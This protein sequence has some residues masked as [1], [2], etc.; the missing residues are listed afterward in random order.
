MIVE[1]DWLCEQLDDPSV[2]ILDAS[3]TPVSGTKSSYEGQFIAGARIFDIDHFSDHLSPLPHMLATASD[4]QHRARFLGI[5]KES[6][7]I[8]YDNQGIYSSPRAWWMFKAMGHEKVAVLNGGL[9][10]WLEKGYPVEK[11]PRSTFPAGNFDASLNDSLVRS[12]EQVAE[13]MRSRSF[14][15]IDARSAR[16]FDGTHPEPR[17]HLPSGHIPQSINIPF[18]AVLEGSRFKSKAALQALFAEIPEEPVVFS[19]GSGLTAC[20]TLLAAELVLENDKAVY[21]GSWTEWA[22]IQGAE[23]ETKS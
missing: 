2:I 20:I 11:K 19:C 10:E 4:F 23:I 3:Y 13:N 8:C 21:D 12:L 16:R 18:Q 22:A 5:D 9:P 6:T 15:L 7:I 17:P 14:Q 1:S